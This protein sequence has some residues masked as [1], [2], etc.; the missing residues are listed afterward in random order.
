VKEFPDLVDT[1]R[2]FQ[3]RSFEFVSIGVEDK[4]AMPKAEKFLK[5]TAVAIPDGLADSLKAEGRTTN[6]YIWTGNVDELAKAIDKD[7]TGALP[8]TVLIGKNGEVL[9]QHSAAVD[10]VELRKQI[11]KALANEG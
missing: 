10:P 8:Y 5:K 4:E 11:V 7:W 1:Y 9:W 6:N 3:R 2:R